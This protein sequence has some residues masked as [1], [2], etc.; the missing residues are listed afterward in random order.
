[1][2]R[3]YDKMF[4][5]LSKMLKPESIKEWSEKAEPCPVCGHKAA[6]IEMLDQESGIRWYHAECG[7]FEDHGAWTIAKPCNFYGIGYSGFCGTIDGVVQVPHHFSP[8]KAVKWWNE[9][10]VPI[11]KLTK[12]SID[13]VHGNTFKSQ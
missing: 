8:E 9:V 7:A 3:G 13:R 10:V 1:M 4:G 2:R 11:A 12:T 5:W 6:L